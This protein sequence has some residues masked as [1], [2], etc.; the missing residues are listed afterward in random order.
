MNTRPLGVTII[1]ILLAIGGVSQVLVGT[2]GLGITSLGIGAVVDA[3]G[4]SGWAAIVGGV[5]T[6]IAAGGLF[7]LKSWAWL[8]VVAVLG[9][10]VIVDVWALVTH[11]TGGAIAGAVIG[12]LVIS[13]VALWYFMRGNVKAAFGR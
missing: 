7:T 12:N 4:I 8:L 10:R 9:I 6:I 3:A 1:A 5:L 13:G 2:E 11:G